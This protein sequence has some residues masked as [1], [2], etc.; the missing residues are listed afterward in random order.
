MITPIDI[1]TMEFKKTGRGYSPD[2]VDEFLN[3]IIVDME[4]LYKDN[5]SYKDRI[6]HLEETI[7][8]Y[9]SNEESIKS[10]I[11]IAEEAAENAKKNAAEQAAVIIKKAQL[12][13]DEKVLE[14][15][16]SLCDIETKTAELKARYNMLSASIRSLIQTELE[17][18]EKSD[19]L[20]EQAENENAS[21]E[22]AAAAENKDEEVPVIELG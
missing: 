7:A 19:A 15:K 22:V 4:K 14:A 2:A 9:K 13:A 5:S 1:E 12:I 20:M 11:L 17:Y 8:Y 10:A 21:E 3:K 6:K 16:R 18:I